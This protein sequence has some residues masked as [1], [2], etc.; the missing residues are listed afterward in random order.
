MFEEISNSNDDLDR[1]TDCV[2]DVI[3]W[4]K[5]RMH[6]LVEDEEIDDATYPDECYGYD[7]FHVDAGVQ[8]MNGPIALKYAR[9]RAT[10]NGDIDRAGRQ[11]AVMLAVRDKL[12]QFN[13]LLKIGI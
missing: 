5:D 9:T 3:E 2:Y 8:N 12:M 11:Q 4:S 13:I 10:A 1:M 7:G 6:T